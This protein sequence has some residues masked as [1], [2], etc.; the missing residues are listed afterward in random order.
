M[1]TLS[2]PPRVGQSS[3]AIDDMSFFFVATY[4]GHPVGLK[5]CWVKPLTSL[6]NKGGVYVFC[7][8][9]LFFSLY[10]NT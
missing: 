6:L 4:Q 2:M 8:F 3:L 5:C 10:N 9:G 7:L 1:A